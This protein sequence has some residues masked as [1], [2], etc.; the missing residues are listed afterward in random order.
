M[1]VA[2]IR[3]YLLVGLETDG[4]DGPNPQIDGTIQPL[5]QQQDPG[6]MGEDELVEIRGRFEL[7]VQVEADAVELQLLQGEPTDFEADPNHAH[8]IAARVQEVILIGGLEPGVG[9]L[10][11]PQHDRIAR[12]E[13][14]LQAIRAPGLGVSPRGSVERCVGRNLVS[15]GQL[16]LIGVRLEASHRHGRDRAEIMRIEDV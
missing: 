10:Q 4:C 7:L 16:S 12:T 8:H 13:A 14:R 9:H 2:G 15:R 11:R 5:R 6:E 1:R 3:Q